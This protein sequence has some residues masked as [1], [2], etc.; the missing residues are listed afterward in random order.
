M[1]AAL[2]PV[3]LQTLFA[4]G[5]HGL[6]RKEGGLAVPI[7][8]SF[9]SWELIEEHCHPIAVGCSLRPPVPW[10]LFQPLFS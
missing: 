8:F 7:A 6:S 1:G 9:S 2:A 4:V 10:C 5:V 3:T